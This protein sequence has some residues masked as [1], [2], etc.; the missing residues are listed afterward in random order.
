VSRDHH[1]RL[2]DILDRIRTARI[3]EVLLVRAQAEGDDDLARTAL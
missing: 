2:V 3:A 1:E